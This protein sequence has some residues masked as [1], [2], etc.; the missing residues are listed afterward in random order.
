MSQLRYVLSWTDA[1]VR[2]WAK[3]GHIDDCVCKKTPGR[4]TVRITPGVPQPGAWRQV[5]ECWRQA[6]ER[7]GTLPPRHHPHATRA[8]Y[9]FR[10]RASAPR[11]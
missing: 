6:V 7:I 10:D 9:A 4:I 1:T 5:W 11:P 2:W 3:L 8:M